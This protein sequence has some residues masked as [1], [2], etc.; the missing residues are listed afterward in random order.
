MSIHI[1]PLILHNIPSGQE[2][3]VSILQKRKIKPRK[4][5]M[6]QPAGLVFQPRS[7]EG[8]LPTIGHVSM[9]AGWWPTPAQT[10]D[11]WTN[12]T[13]KRQILPLKGG[14]NVKCP[15]KR[16]PHTEFTDWWP[17]PREEKKR[18]GFLFLMLNFDNK[19][20]N[21]ASTY[22]DHQALVCPSENSQ[23]GLGWENQVE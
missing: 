6:P 5:K 4:S 14:G 16:K 8:L 23:H 13:K 18:I 21:M 12:A 2:V 22:K 9:R 19:L 15:R 17:S 3:L 20:W 11:S 10:S 1:S 7:S